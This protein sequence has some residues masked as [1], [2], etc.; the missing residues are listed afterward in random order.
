MTPYILAMKELGYVLRRRRAARAASLAIALCGGLGAAGCGAGD[1]GGPV[2]R[3][4]GSF[5][6]WSKGERAAALQWDGSAYRGV[7]ELP[8]DALQLQLYL[9][10][11][12]DLVGGGPQVGVV[13]GRLA[14]TPPG[15]AAPPLRIE[16]PLSAR[17]ELSYDPS[18]RRLSIDLA[19]DAEADQSPGAALLVQALRGADRATP[20]ERAQRAADLAAALKDKGIETPLRS[21]K[22][23]QQGLTFLQLGRADG[24][25]S[26]VGDFNDWT[27]GRDVLQA[28]L[29]GNLAYHARSASG[30]R[31]EYRLNLGGGRYADPLNSEVIWDGAYLPSNLQNVLGGNVGDF[32]SI[33]TSP[34]YVEQGSRL[35]RLFVKGRELFV[36]LPPGYAAATRDYPSI[37]IHDGK[38]AI[39]RGRYNQSLDRLIS[40]GTVPPVVGVFLPAQSDPNARLSEYSHV[41]DPYF[42]DVAP[43][44]AE[45]Q[46]FILDAVLPEIERQFRVRRDPAQRAMLGIDM[47]GP[48][49]FYLAWKDPQRRVLRVASQSGRFGW[50][51]NDPTRSPYIE[52]LREDR[53]AVMKRVSFDWADGD[54]FQVQVH[55]SVLRPLIGNNMG[56]QGKAQFLRQDKPAPVMSPTVWDNW[57]MRLDAALSFLLG[58]LK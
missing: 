27:E 4:S 55:D 20:A 46:A 22:G 24:A 48:F 30:V 29:D 11:T 50:G 15:R 9:P 16:T 39:V 10:Y 5:N 1:F 12:G 47:A 17:Y 21:G 3:L 7:V 14:T 32:N 28:T 19:A 36:Y 38:D 42:A 40:A 25:A 53:S 18:Q 43:K 51:N 56:W 57:R 33:A 44:G 52:A 6:G 2:A 58:D 41:K 49:S 37:Y 26:I 54:P 34:G 23:D 31:L 13:P 8:G 35:R 45:Y